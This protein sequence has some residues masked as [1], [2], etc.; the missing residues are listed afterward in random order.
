M[1]EF[2]ADSSPLRD[3][4]RAN[5]DVNATKEKKLTNMRSLTDDELGRPIPP[6]KVAQA[7]LTRQSAASKKAR[8]LAAV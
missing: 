5:G 4:W 6:R 1:S 8:G 3:H 7:A 2:C